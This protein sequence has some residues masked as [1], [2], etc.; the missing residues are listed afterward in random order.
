MSATPNDGLRFSPFSS[1]EQQLQR[2]VRLLAAEVSGAFKAPRRIDQ[3]K[4][5]DATSGACWSAEIGTR[6]GTNAV[7]RSRLA[8]HHALMFS[9]M[10][11]TL[12]FGCQSV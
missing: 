4:L 7:N 1:F 12:T 9:R 3:G 5:H 10:R 2:I 6:A 8:F 11:G